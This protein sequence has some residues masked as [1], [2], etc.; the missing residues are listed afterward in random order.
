M[1]V[2]RRL[3]LAIERV[4]MPH[5]VFIGGAG[6]LHVPGTIVVCTVDHPDF[7]IAYRRAIADSHT[8]TSY[9]EEKLGHTRVSLRG[10]RNARLA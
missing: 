2:T 4:E 9:M 10:Y 7:F 6:S 3:I 5:F 8:H 1:E